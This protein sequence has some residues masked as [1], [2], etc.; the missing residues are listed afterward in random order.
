MKFDRK[1]A[2]IAPTIV[3]ALV[4]AGMVY[5]VLQ[6][7]LLSGIS[8]SLAERRV[9]IEQVKRGEKPLDTHQALNIIDAQFDVEG[10]RSAALTELRS[11]LSILAGIG[12]V[13]VV[14]LAVGVRGVERKHWPGARR[15][16]TA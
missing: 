14:V 1:L 6:V 7:R 12:F 15:R 2:L 11:L 5:A 8:E 3:L 9:F 4:V 13:S 10:R 16:E